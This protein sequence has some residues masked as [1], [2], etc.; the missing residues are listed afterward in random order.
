MTDHK[1]R[2][3]IQFEIYGEKGTMDS[4][5]NWSPDGE[6]RGL[7]DRVARFFVDHYEK[8]YFAYQE[9]NWEA[10]RVRREADERA[11]ELA[12]LERLQRK[13]GAPE[14]KP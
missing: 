10:D 12:E 13:Y 6:I 3:K 11:R 2:I 4:W 5:I 9:S 1:A 14:V 8:A 7:D